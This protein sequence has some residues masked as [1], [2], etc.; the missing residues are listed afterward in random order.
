MN[1]LFRN[2][3]P[4]AVAVA[5]AIAWVRSY[6]DRRAANALAEARS[7]SLTAALAIGDSLRS[8][9][10]IKA[11]A[12]DSL[13]QEQAAYYR[14]DRARYYLISKK[15][16]STAAVLD[17]L[18]A[19]LPDTMPLRIAIINERIAGASCR[20]AL[21]SCDSLTTLQL[22]ELAVSDSLRSLDQRENLRLRQLWTEAVK[23]R[24]P[25]F[26]DHLRSGA[27]GGALVAVIALLLR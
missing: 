13:R 4:Y 26:G 22:A 20:L 16:D 2:A 14:S 18:L 21:R 7:D 27:V 10:R 6:G 25:S 17:S 1:A 19:A 8:S 11:L 9:L 15:A 5:L 24:G 23:Q 3:A 12:L